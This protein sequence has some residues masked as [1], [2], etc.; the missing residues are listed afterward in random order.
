MDEPFGALDAITRA[1][2]QDELRRIHARFGQTILFVTHDIEEAVRLADRIVV[3]REGRVVQYDTPPRIIMAPADVFVADLVGADDVLRRLS[4][5][6]V[7]GGAPPAG[8]W[9]AR[10][11]PRSRPCRARRGCG[12][13]WR[14][15]WKA[16]Q[17]PGRG[18]RRRRRP[19]GTLDL[20]AIQTGERA[21]GAWRRTWRRQRRR[22]STMGS[23]V[24][25]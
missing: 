10:R 6:S 19:V 24:E 11:T 3:M 13:R 25:S 15:C 1:R 8:R 2:L 12:R 22:S 7:G 4:L 5:I 21:D 23:P 9:R 20:R 18:R 14:C 17:L 16:R